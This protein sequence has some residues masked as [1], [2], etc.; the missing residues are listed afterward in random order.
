M[1]MEMEIDRPDLISRILESDKRIVLIVGLPGSGKTH[2]LRKFADLVGSTVQS[3]DFIISTTVKWSIWD[4]PGSDISVPQDVNLIIAARPDE[5]PQALDRLRLYGN[6]LVLETKDLLLPR[7]QC[8]ADI[9]D[10]SGGWPVL[11]SSAAADDALLTRYLAVEV[12]EPFDLDMLWDGLEAHE[13]PSPVDALFSSLVDCSS[14]AAKRLRELLPKAMLLTLSRKITDTDPDGLD[15]RIARSPDV[16]DDLVCIT[17]TRGELAA[18][19]SIF[20]FS[21]GWYLFYRIGEARFRRLL[22]RF[23]PGMLNHPEVTLCHALLSLKE[24]EIGTARSLL[25]KTFGDGVLDVLDVLRPGN[26]LPIRVRVFRI[27]MLIYDDQSLTD[28]IMTALYAF[29]A[30]LPPDSWMLRG[31]YH[32]ALLEFQLRLRNLAAAENAAVRAEK[33]YHQ[34]S[35][36]LLSFYVSIH[37]AVTRILQGETAAA[38]SDLIKAAEKLATVGFDSP[39]DLRIVTF[40]QAVVEFDNAVPGPLLDFIESEHESFNRGELWPTLTEM[41]ILYGSQIV[42]EQ[43]SA[44]A[45]MSFLD[46]WQL[47]QTHHLASRRFVELRRAQILQNANRWGEGERILRSVKSSINRVWVESAESGLSQLSARDDVLIA[48]TWLRQ[49]VYERPKLLYLDRKL[50]A[51]RT[52][53]RL[54]GRQRM[55]IDIWRAYVARDA[56]RLSDAK[57]ILLAIF[58]VASRRSTLSV[59]SEE[60]IFLTELWSDQRL[61]VFLRGA[62]TPHGIMRRLSDSRDHGM[63]ATARAL[64]TKQEVKVLLLLTD[65]ASNKNIARRL[66]LSEPTVKFHLKNLYRK[67]GCR[68]RVETVQTA[69]SLGWFR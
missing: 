62:G 31:S 4:A 32:N 45:A 29:G 11:M 69:R 8:D 47:F 23:P 37:R 59:L 2:L 21:G 53:P 60:N 13:I 68:N 40:L 57:G 54:T 34:A 36:P 19:V 65:G 26:G 16:I 27:V 48:F 17:M 35:I 44:R 9:W 51:M 39:G 6:I 7:R 64:L 46:Q 63:A 43:M 15:A 42:S 55:S 61:E 5:I 56:G 30:E 50:D 41:A 10:Q 12:L 22:R 28:A 24:G 14:R 67:L 58:E 25:A 18:A 1:E 52:N 38:R 20:E 33:A 3:T 49:I 66:G